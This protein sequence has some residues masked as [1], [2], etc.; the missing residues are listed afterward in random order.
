MQPLTRG[1]EDDETKTMTVA[2]PQHVCMPLSKRRQHHLVR[3]TCA[4]AFGVRSSPLGADKLGKSR[5]MSVDMLFTP[6]LLV[7]MQPNICSVRAQSVRDFVTEI[8]G[9]AMPAPVRCGS[10]L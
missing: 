7:L 4:D 2:R 3:S 9:G 6:V 5:N 8:S 10:E 1:P